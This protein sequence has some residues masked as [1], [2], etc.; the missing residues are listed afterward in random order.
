MYAH[1]FRDD[2]KTVSRSKNK[3]HPN[4]TIHIVI[5]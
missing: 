4:I 3:E 2:M 1:T 5:A